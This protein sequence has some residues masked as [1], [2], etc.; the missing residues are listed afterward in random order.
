M[1]GSK[2]FN[3]PVTK[4]DLWVFDSFTL[5]FQLNVHFSVSTE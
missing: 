4:P 2:I 3:K 5:D 1:V